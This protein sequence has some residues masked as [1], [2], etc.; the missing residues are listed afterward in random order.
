MSAWQCATLQCSCGAVVD[1]GAT[2]CAACGAVSE[3]WLVERLR[4]ALK[5]RMR[6]SEATDLALYGADAAM[7]RRQPKEMRR[8][9]KMAL[10]TASEPAPIMRWLEGQAPDD[11]PQRR[12][13]WSQ[14]CSRAALW[15][16]WQNV[17]STA[18]PVPDLL[19]NTGETLAD[20]ASAPVARTEALA[21]PASA[22]VARS[23]A[24]ADPASAPVARTEALADPASAPVARTEALAE[25][26]SAPVACSEALAELPSAPVARSEALAELPSAPVACSEALADSASAPVACSEA[27]AEDGVAVPAPSGLP[28]L[29]GKFSGTEV[30]RL[31]S[32]V[33]A[34]MLVGIDDPCRGMLSDEVAAAFDEATQTLVRKGVLAVDDARRLVVDSA[35]CRAAET[36]AAPGCVV[37]VSAHEQVRYFYVRDACILSLQA[38]AFAPAS[39]VPRPLPRTQDADYRLKTLSDIEALHDEVTSTLCRRATLP[40]PG[41]SLRISGVVSARARAK[42]RA[43]GVEAAA[44]VLRQAGCD[45]AGLQALALALVRARDNASAVCMTRP[46]PDQWQSHGLGVLVGDAGT[47]A[48]TSA[49]EGEE[50]WIEFTPTG[51]EPLRA[52]ILELLAPCG[53][54]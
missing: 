16:M 5:V 44:G 29:E 51:A 3:P 47:W 17:T 23:E 28:P 34:R 22:P 7:R 50:A 8:F 21:D 33:G 19:T 52:R 25:L 42:A 24:L 1:F 39:A 37:V 54:D 32:L 48:L 10:E 15:D 40:A 9:L 11:L 6:L 14:G 53:E 18:V 31:A 36:L 4:E 49:F 46:G 12:E 2:A 13:A 35:W 45:E 30:A 41:A 26:P 27:L 20:S 38:E 43:E